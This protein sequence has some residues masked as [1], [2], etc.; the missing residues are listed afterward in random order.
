[1]LR[2]G[3]ERLPV[4]RLVRRACSDTPECVVLH[5]LSPCSAAYLRHGVWSE[6][7]SAVSGLFLD[8][9]SSTAALTPTQGVGQLAKNRVNAGP[10]RC[11]GPLT[12]G[13]CPV[14]RKLE[15]SRR[16]G[17]ASQA[18]AKAHAASM[19]ASAQGLSMSAARRRIH[20]KSGRFKQPVRTTCLSCEQP[21]CG[22]P[23]KACALGSTGRF[24]CRGSPARKNIGLET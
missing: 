1:M 23:H 14:C 22:K 9:A 2:C 18:P 12:R 13:S 11:Q 10:L 5:V 15:T 7:L 6:L 19:S 17:E 24:G 16:V 20:E 8:G 21:V 4:Q 3:S